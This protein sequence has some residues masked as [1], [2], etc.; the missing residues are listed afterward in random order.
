MKPNPFEQLPT[1]V[2]I[3]NQ[4]VPINS[5][6]R[7]GVSIETECFSDAPDLVGLL[8]LFYLGSIPQ[9]VHE[10]VEQMVWFYKSHDVHTKSNTSGN[11]KT[12]RWYDFEQ[13]ADALFASFLD[14]YG[15]DLSVAR[16]HWW[17]FRR[18][19]LNLPAESQFMQRVRYRT[20]DT[21]KL[22]KEEKKYY[23]KM[24]DL[25]AIKNKSN[26]GLTVAE[27]EAALRE[28]SQRL[29]EEARRSIEA[30]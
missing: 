30:R 15:I 2:L 7:V 13:D 14:T 10:A 25:Y 29:A 20:I 17:A 3:D 19:M 4:Q 8:N 1:T 6:F 24:R 18:L 9:N 12:S 27:R 28:R 16:L 21:K 26:D 22:G 5:D 23:K 11:G